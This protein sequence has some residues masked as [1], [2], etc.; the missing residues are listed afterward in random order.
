MLALGLTKIAKEIRNLFLT[1]Q[2]NQECDFH[3]LPEYGDSLSIEK[4]Q[5][6]KVSF[7]HFL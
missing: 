5:T 6:F 4:R 7:L 2:Y 3:R 1:K